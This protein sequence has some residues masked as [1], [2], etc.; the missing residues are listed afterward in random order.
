MEILSNINRLRR[1]AKR[2][3]FVDNV[4]FTS[5]SQKEAYNLMT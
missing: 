1:N 4:I 3:E 2:D 5:V